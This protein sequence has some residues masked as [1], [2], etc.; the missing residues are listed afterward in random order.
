MCYKCIEKLIL[1]ELPP[2]QMAAI[3]PSLLNIHPVQK[4]GKWVFET[5][6]DC[7]SSTTESLEKLTDMAKSM[8]T[9]MNLSIVPW[10]FRVITSS[11]WK[12]E[13]QLNSAL[14]NS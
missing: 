3:C 14:E 9:E 1:V 12:A 13:K 11:R 5:E 2:L 4:P 6:D 7:E 8:L 10:E